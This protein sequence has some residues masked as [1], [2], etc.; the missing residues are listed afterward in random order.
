MKLVAVVFVLLLSQNSFSGY[1]NKCPGYAPDHSWEDLNAV[2]A[3]A[4]GKAFARYA[5]KAGF[6]FDMEAYMADTPHWALFNFGRATG[7]SCLTVDVLSLF[8]NLDYGLAV[9]YSKTFVDG[10][11]PKLVDATFKKEFV[12]LAEMYGFDIYLT[13]QGEL[14]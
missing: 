1:E 14:V 9:Y 8:M 5:E 6:D 4:A 10:A 3:W 13:P 7:T 2:T 12:R 11:P